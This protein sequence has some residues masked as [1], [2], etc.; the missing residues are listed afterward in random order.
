MKMKA[1]FNIDIPKRNSSCSKG[2][3]PLTAGAEIFSLVVE[4]DEGFLRFDYCPECWK[5]LEGSE[6]VKDAVTS[7]KSIVP[8][9]KQ[10]KEVYANR[11]EA[12]LALFKKTAHSEIEEERQHAYI[13]SLYLARGRQIY[14]RKEMTDQQGTPCQV[15]EFA[16]SEEVICI[17]RF[18]IANLPIEQIQKAIAQ[19]IKAS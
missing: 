9:V 19:K 6:S 16:D 5:T 7:W 18:D 17:Q 3:E 4:G 2:A 8:E 14:L 13:L 11:N 12:A 1:Y 10:E 15:Y